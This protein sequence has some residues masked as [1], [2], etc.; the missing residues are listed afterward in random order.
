MLLLADFQRPLKME[1]KIFK[2]EVDFIVDS[3]E[4]GAVADFIYRLEQKY[5]L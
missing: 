5:T 2:K 4:N 3:C 1:T